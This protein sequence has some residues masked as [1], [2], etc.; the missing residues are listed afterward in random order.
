MTQAAEVV[1]F[2][3]EAGI[4]RWFAKDEAFDHEIR[5]RFEATHFAAA[6]RGHE[7]WLQDAEGA[8]ALLLL[9]DQFPRNLFRG[10]A[11]AWAADPLARHYAAR[12]LAAGHDQAFEPLLRGFFYLPWEHSEDAADQARSVEL[13]RALGDATYL[14][15]AIEH[16]QVITRFGRFPHRNRA[17]GRKTTPE[18]Q[19]WL[20]AGGGF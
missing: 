17:L 14:D 5:R 16:E 10:S 3:R 19:A 20:D 11:H 6:R 7:D 1:T 2:W 18:E 9:L 15:Y 8:L 4:A 13:F 12:A